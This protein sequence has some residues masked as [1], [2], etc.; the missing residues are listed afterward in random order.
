MDGD[1]PIGRRRLLVGAGVGLGGL[2]L[3]GIPTAA[4]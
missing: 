1:T 2:V 4:S 3:A